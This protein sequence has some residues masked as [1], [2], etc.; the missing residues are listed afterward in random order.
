MC[1]CT[2]TRCLPLLMKLCISTSS[3]QLPSPEPKP[4]PFHLPCLMLVTGSMAS[5]LQ[6]WVFTFRPGVAMLLKLTYWL[7]VPFHSS[8][9]S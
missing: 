2:S 8:S 1:H 4:W 7:G 9:Y 6:R 5:H 3:Q